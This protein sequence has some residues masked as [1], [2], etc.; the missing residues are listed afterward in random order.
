M[1]KAVKRSLANI[2]ARTMDILYMYVASNS[3]D[4]FIK[5]ELMVC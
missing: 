5:N 4:I 3:N 1:I 2:V